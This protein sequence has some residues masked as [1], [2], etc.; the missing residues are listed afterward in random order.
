MEPQVDW[1]ALVIQVI[2]RAIELSSVQLADSRSNLQSAD[3]RNQL[4]KL[5]IF[6]L[7]MCL[8]LLALF[9]PTALKLTSTSTSQQNCIWPCNYSMCPPFLLCK[10]FLR[11][12]SYLWPRL[13]INRNIPLIS[14]VPQNIFS[15]E[16]SYIWIFSMYFLKE[17]LPSLPH[18]H[19]I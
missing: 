11:S 19:E 12:Y 15:S 13:V 9:F 16:I 5:E 14:I 8:S 10:G 7:Q 1:L 6:S 18:P 4:G 17:M 3:S 2:S